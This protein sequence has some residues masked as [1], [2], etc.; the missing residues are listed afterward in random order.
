[1]VS[2]EDAIYYGKRS[3]PRGEAGKAFPLPVKPFDV[4]P[5]EISSHTQ[6]AGSNETASEYVAKAIGSAGLKKYSDAI[7]FIDKAINLDRKAHGPY[8]LKAEVYMNTSEYARARKE[9]EK[10]GDMNSVAPEVYYFL[11]C[12]DIEEKKAESAK[13]NLRKALYIDGRFVPA[14]IMLAN[15]H[16]GEG[17]T[18]EAIREYRNSLKA[19]LAR[20]PDDVLAYS[21]GFSVVSLIGVCRDNLERLKAE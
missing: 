12:I 7:D 16:K 13:N 18:T 5:I 4:I 2:W 19:L 6:A 21:G 1:M 9:L 10:A 14:R 15:M 11:G 17:R 8:V 3:G 20:K